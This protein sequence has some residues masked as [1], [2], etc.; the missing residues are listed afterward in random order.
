MGNKCGA[1]GKLVRRGQSAHKHT[2]AQIDCGG[3]GCLD[4][5]VQ[6]A[7][8]VIRLHIWVHWPALPRVIVI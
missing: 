2:Y 3:I 8:K 4:L 6:A 1:G 5:R 7:K